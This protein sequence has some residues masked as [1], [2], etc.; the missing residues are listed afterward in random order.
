M[1]GN[2]SF[3]AAKPDAL[4]RTILDWA[5]Q[6]HSGV[7]NHT[8]Q[9]LD[10]SDTDWVVA[11]LPKACKVTRTT[12]YLM[13]VTLPVTPA[14]LDEDATFIRYH[15]S[16]VNTLFSVCH[17]PPPCEFQLAVG[18]NFSA[19][20]GEG[21][22]F[23]DNAHGA[24]FYTWSRH[25]D[26][27]L[28]ALMLAQAPQCRKGSS[29]SNRALRSAHKHRV[30]AAVIFRCNRTFTNEPPVAGKPHQIMRLPVPEAYR[31]YVLQSMGCNEL[32]MLPAVC[33]GHQVHE[34]VAKPGLT[35]R[36]APSSVPQRAAPPAPTL[37][38]SSAQWRQNQLFFLRDS[39]PPLPDGQW[40]CLTRS[41]RVCIYLEESKSTFWPRVFPP[42]N[43]PEE[44]S[45]QEAVAAEVPVNQIS[46]DVLTPRLR[47]IVHST[48]SRLSL[49]DK[50]LT[51]VRLTNSEFTTVVC[52]N[53]WDSLGD[54]QR[55]VCKV[56][57]SGQVRTVIGEIF[58]SSASECSRQVRARTKISNVAGGVM[59]SFT[60]ASAS[61]P[62]AVIH[63][64]ATSS[65][66]SSSH[67][68]DI[69]T[70][71]GLNLTRCITGEF[72][73]SAVQTVRPFCDDCFF[74]ISADQ[75]TAWLDALRCAM[76]RNSP[77]L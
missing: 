18:W 43:T 57:D 34:L 41:A 37:G 54:C 13:F 47:Q 23:A 9:A 48:S 69:Q 50:L 62:K 27:S 56:G 65:T 21:L 63:Y 1:E 29:G 52:S 76:D 45:D 44:D 58:L 42:V 74:K 75:R 73:Q 33:P 22:Y 38:T 39:W 28:T 32:G 7:V 36:E 60:W 66:S 59:D 77:G 2:P 10:S 20:S 71:C 67:A 61:Q 25:E 53:L 31:Q 5:A 35:L 8:W 64:R 46:W 6:K 49:S 70:L 19:K 72:L 40:Y 14:M 12:R 30:V 16:T 17:A 15:C 4:E 11:H 51:V 24:L 68:T 26:R 55:Q 3:E